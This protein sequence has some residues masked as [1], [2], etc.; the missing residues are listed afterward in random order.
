M[1]VPQR[2][3]LT[4]VC[5]SNGCIIDEALFPIFPIFSDNCLASIYKMTSTWWKGTQ[6]SSGNMNN[7]IFPKVYPVSASSES[8]FLSRHDAYCS[9][10]IRK[11]GT[12]L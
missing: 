4:D 10:F 9:E 5:L 8:A 6:V 7:N 11:L 3:I 2:W 12:T 1:H